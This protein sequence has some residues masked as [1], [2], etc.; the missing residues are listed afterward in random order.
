MQE[1]TGVAL[2]LC[3]WKD[4]LL[5]YQGKMWTPNE[6]KLRVEVIKQHHDNPTIGH[7]GTAK[8]TQLIQRKYYWPHMSDLIKNIHQELGHL[9]KNKSSQTCTIQTTTAKQS[10]GKNRW[11][12]ISMDFITDLPKSEGYDA[13]LV[14]I[15]RLTKMS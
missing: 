11:K 9:S 8:T 7:G 14:V 3:Q 5:W 4:N 6:D 12:S 10:T 1:M 15:D 13:I 2:G